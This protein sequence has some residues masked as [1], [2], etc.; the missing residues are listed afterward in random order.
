MNND[1]RE[2]GLAAL[3]LRRAGYGLSAKHTKDLDPLP[4]KADSEQGIISGYASNFWVIDSYGEATAPG[5]FAQSIKERGPQGT[6]RIPFRYEH[7]YTIGN[8]TKMAEDPDGL[9][10]DAKITDDGQWGT[11]LRR[12]L[13]DGVPYG[14]SIGYRTLSARPGTVDD[15]FI[16]DSAPRWLREEQ[17]PASIY[18]LTSLKLMENSGVTFPA[19]EPSII[20]RYRADAGQQLETLLASVKAGLLTPTQIGLLREIAAQL[21]AVPVSERAQA[22]TPPDGT[23]DSDAANEITI[24]LLEMTIASIERFVAA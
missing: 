21:P 23:A 8:H 7:Q 17:D 19:N 6:N 3:T 12:Q 18:V 15:P 13:A 22:A 4:I 20:D 5:C 10:I 14:L 11:V 1:E 2:L 16:W 24:N 9:A